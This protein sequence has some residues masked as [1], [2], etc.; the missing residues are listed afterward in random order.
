MSDWEKFKSLK[1]KV[2]KELRQTKADYFA[3]LSGS[4]GISSNPR[5]AWNLLNAAIRPKCKSNI[6][7][8]CTPTGEFTSPNDIVN[9]FNNHFSALFSSLPSASLSD[10][11]FVQS[12]SSF[13]SNYS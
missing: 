11:N 10:F 1:K 12:H 8:I 2:N 4:T 13:C 7:F 9:L 6:G 3:T 5:K